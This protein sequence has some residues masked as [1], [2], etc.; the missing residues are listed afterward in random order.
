MI[1]IEVRGRSRD[2]CSWN[3]AA[4]LSSEE[5]PFRPDSPSTEIREKMR[6][7]DRQSVRK[8]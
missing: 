2:D 3:V 6:V 5:C 8:A 1:G 4:L 7:S